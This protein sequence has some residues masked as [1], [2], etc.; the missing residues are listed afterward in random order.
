MKKLQK[1]FPSYPYVLTALALIICLFVY[2]LKLIGHTDYE[3]SSLETGIFPNLVLTDGAIITSEFTPA[4]E[5]LDHISFRFLSSGNAPEGTVTLTLFNKMQEQLADVTLESG[6]I[7]NY[8]WIDFSIDAKLEPDEIYTW[9]LRAHDYNE[10]EASLSLYSGGISTGPKESGTLYY[11]GEK[12]ETF[13]P[14]V[15]FSYTDRVDAEH[16]LPYYVVIILLGLLLFST[17]RKFEQTSEE[18][19]P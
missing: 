11:N 15:I 16:A 14:A 7:M 13:T 18:I 5:Q 19:Q 9:Q 10:E 6:D 12:E 8:R 2:P 17:C 1:L 3:S 4:H